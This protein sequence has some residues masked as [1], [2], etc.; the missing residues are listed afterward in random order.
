MRPLT[1]IQLRWVPV[2][3]SNVCLQT[4]LTLI[5]LVGTSP[6]GLNRSILSK[7]PIRTFER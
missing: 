2:S 4:I 1:E 3:T 5:L 6:R 7:R